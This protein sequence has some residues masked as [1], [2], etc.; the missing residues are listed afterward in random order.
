MSKIMANNPDLSLLKII[1]RSTA[2]K[3]PYLQMKKNSL[4][5]KFLIS[6][7]TNSTKKIP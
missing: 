3:V 2:I 1:L 4:L 5:K 6:K 7:T